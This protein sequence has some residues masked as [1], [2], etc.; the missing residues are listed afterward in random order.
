MAL[1]GTEANLAG[2]TKYVAEDT[3][4]L[5]SSSAEQGGR[6]NAGVAFAFAKPPV[7]GLV[8]SSH[9]AADVWPLAFVRPPARSYWRASTRPVRVMAPRSDS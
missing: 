6:G 7:P 4:Y 5:V 8:W 3:L 1:T 9:T 2:A